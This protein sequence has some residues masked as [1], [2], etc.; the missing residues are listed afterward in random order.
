MANLTLV[1]AQ[2]PLARPLEEV[3]SSVSQNREHSLCLINDDD[4]N[5]FRRL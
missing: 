5:D 1:P 4:L 3:N 2:V